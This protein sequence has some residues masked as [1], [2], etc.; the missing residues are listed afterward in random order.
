MVI[1]LGESGSSLRSSRLPPTS[2]NSCVGCWDVSLSY[3]VTLCVSTD[4]M[5]NNMELEH[6]TGLFNYFPNKALLGYLLDYCEFQ[7]LAVKHL[8]LII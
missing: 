5:Y 6:T 3:T 2:S 4:A 8:L 1:K 7:C